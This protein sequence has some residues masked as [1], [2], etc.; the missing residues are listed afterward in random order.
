M[1]IWFRTPLLLRFL[2]IAS[3]WAGY[4]YAVSVLNT[5]ETHEAIGASVMIAAA[6][7]GFLTVQADLWL[8]KRFESAE[9]F[10][11][12]R[13]ALRSGALPAG[14][15]SRQWRRWLRGSRW[16]NRATLVIGAPYVVFGLISAV[17]TQ[18][19][20]HFVLVSLC[21]V[22]AGG[23]AQLLLKRSIQI[24]RLWAEVKRLPSEPAGVVEEPVAPPASPSWREQGYQTKLPSRIVM[25]AL[26]GLVLASVAFLLADLEAVVYDVAHIMNPMWAFTL[27]AAFTVACAGVISEPFRARDFAS[28]RQYDDYHR[29]IQTGVVPCDLDVALWRRR[30]RSTQRENDI[31]LIAATILI[32]VG[33][34]AVV[35]GPTGYHVVI[36]V[37]FELLA[38]WLLLKWWRVRDWLR[39]IV[40]QVD[41]RG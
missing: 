39:A 8:D 17:G 10:R 41:N 33:A 37:S 19:R 27:I 35:A 2:A 18:W 22:S 21:V 4:A 36:A 38:L 20:F 13:Q 40:A 12:Y 15:D 6:V 25:S 11:A 31:K 3:L 34:A 1:D 26:V 32:A 5:P 24:R 29:S 16:A 14:A 9:Q 7:G 23:G 30:L 28:Y